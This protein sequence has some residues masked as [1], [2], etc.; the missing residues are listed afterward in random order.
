MLFYGISLMHPCKQAGWSLSAHPDLD[1]MQEYSLL[2][3][4]IRVGYA[5]PD[6]LNEQN[7]SSLNVL[8]GLMIEKE[9]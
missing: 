8:V 4:N 7:V 5:K 2:V 3:Y 9:F 1:Q 6:T